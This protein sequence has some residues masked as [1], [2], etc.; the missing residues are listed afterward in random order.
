MIN[1][2]ENHIHGS[3]E[4]KLKRY[5]VDNNIQCEHLIFDES[6]HSVADAAKAANANPSN[7]VKNICFVTDD[8]QLIVAIIKGE[9]RASSKRIT[10]TLDMGSVR[11][12]TPKEILHFSGYPC[13]GTPSFG[14]NGI[15]I[16]DPKV[17]DNEII[18]TGGGSQRSLIKIATEILQQVNSA[19]IQRIRS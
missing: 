11:T 12:A 13:G 2:K 5:I 17:L 3:F 4:T 7:F 6:C 10:K 15:F 16:M 8:D 19:T 14:F 18:Y 1:E 9:H